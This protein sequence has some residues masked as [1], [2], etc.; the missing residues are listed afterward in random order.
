MRVRSANGVVADY[1]AEGGE[2]GGRLYGAERLGRLER[3]LGRR[4][5][6]L[7]VGSADLLPGKAG[8]FEAYPDG[9][10]RLLLKA[11]PTNELVWHELGHFTQ[12]RSLGSDAYRALPRCE[13]F[14][15]PE[16]H[17]FDLLE[18]PTRWYRLTPAYRIHSAEY[19]EE[20]G[21]FR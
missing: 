17:V 12:W 4:G 6:T 16:Q 21:G 8:T 18:R 7:E 2:I 10:A 13:S 1:A 11:N 14:N 9:S 15:A 5:V 3:Y 20:V 19:I